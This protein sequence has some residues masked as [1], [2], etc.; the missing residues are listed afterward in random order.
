MQLRFREIAASDVDRLS[1]WMPGQTWPY[2]SPAKVDAS[3]VHERAASGYF[4]SDTTRSFWAL[5][6]GGITIIGLARVFE[7][8]DVTPLVDLRMGDDFR[9]QGAGTLLLRWITQW[10]FDSF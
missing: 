3:W 2:H 9:G 4:F 1:G 10:V 6:D 5:A 8:T 7:L